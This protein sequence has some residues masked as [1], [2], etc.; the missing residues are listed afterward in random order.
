MSVSEWHG[1]GMVSSGGIYCLFCVPS[2]EYSTFSLMSFHSNFQHLSMLCPGQCFLPFYGYRMSTVRM[3]TFIHLLFDEHVG[4]LLWA[5]LLER[6]CLHTFVPSSRSFRV[7]LQAVNPIFPH[8]NMTRAPFCIK[9]LFPWRQFSR[10]DSSLLFN[11]W[12]VQH[13]FLWEASCHCLGRGHFSCCIQ[14]NRPE[15]GYAV[16]HTVFC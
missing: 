8:L 3:S 4:H 6:A 1:G 9:R 7:G 12:E 11:A 13:H 5:M 10:T 2:S 15:F 16:Y 14:H